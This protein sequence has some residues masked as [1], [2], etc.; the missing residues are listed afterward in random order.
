MM[1]ATGKV[2]FLNDLALKS[3]V[4]TE[5]PF[6]KALGIKG[7]EDPLLVIF[8]VFS[9]EAYFWTMANNMKEA[10]IEKVKF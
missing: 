7:P 2:E 9:G 8:R 1:R 5:R 3:R 4:L 6:L 10:E